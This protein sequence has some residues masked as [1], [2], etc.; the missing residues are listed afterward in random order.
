ME[1][2]PQRRAVH[3]PA[4]RR[5]GEWPGQIEV[6]DDAIR[7]QVPKVCHGRPVLLAQGQRR[8]CPA[9]QR[10]I[11]VDRDTDLAEVADGTLAPIEQPHQH[12]REVYSA[13][14]Q[15]QYPRPVDLDRRTIEVEDTSR[16]RPFLGQRTS[17]DPIAHRLQQHPHRPAGRRGANRDP[18]VDL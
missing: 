9:H 15:Q 11:D 8:R 1:H 10:T 18:S 5:R 7:H 4:E 16:W 3:D 13:L 12:R 17:T 2:D 6:R 14:S